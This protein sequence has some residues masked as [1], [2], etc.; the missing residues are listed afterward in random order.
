MSCEKILD[1]V[2]EY[3]SG[4]KRGDMPLLT[5]IRVGLHI[6]VCPDCAQVLD[7]FE[8]YKDSSYSELSSPIITMMIDGKGDESKTEGEDI[9]GGFSTRGWVIAGLVML[10]SLATAF[11]GLDFNKIAREM[12]MSFLLPI[13]ITIGIVLTVYG[14]IFIGSHLKELTERFYKGA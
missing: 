12:G 7:R 6:L 3:S 10:V 13:G 9:P 5:R 2:Y 4:E 8:V 11:F 14:A 1:K